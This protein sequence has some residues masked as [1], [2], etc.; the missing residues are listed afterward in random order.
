M[1]AHD[2]L[3]R[4]REEFQAIFKEHQ[5]AHEEKEANAVTA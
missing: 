4:D 5:E 3:T 2:D 1:Q